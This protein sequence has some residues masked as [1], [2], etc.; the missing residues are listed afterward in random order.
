V[1]VEMVW[2]PVK[3]D[4]SAVATHPPV[5][6]LLSVTVTAPS[7][8]VTVWGLVAAVT[9]PRF[10][11]WAGALIPRSPPPTST[12]TG[13]EEAV[14]AS[15]GTVKASIPVP[16]AINAAAIVVFRIFFTPHGV[17]SWSGKSALNSKIA[18]YLGYWKLAETFHRIS[19]IRK[20]KVP[21]AAGS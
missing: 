6:A 1:L 20:Y 4:A 17:F 16:P 21:G 7:L 10:T 3:S 19:R 8:E 11:D 13:V 5:P 14:A 15:A 2:G 12:V 18:A 9:D